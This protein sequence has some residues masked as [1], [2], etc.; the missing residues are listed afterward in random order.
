MRGAELRVR[1]GVVAACLIGLAGLV[2]PG[3]RPAG[4]SV[5]AVQAAPR[6]AALLTEGFEGGGLGG[7]TAGGLC[8]EEP[9]FCGWRVAADSVH[10]GSGAA[11]APGSGDRS[12]Q[13]LTSGPLVIPVNATLIDANFWHRYL[14]EAGHDGAVLEYSTDGGATWLD[15]GSRISPGY[16]GTIAS[17]Q[18]PL[19]GR[20][21]WTGAAPEWSQVTVDLRGLT[22]ATLY[23]R[24]RLGADE[25]LNSPGWWIDDVVVCADTA[26]GPARSAAAFAS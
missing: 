21:A 6:R 18:N 17:A 12:D 24:F 4:D 26:A 16:S 9:A 8:L 1:L 20:A 13:R 25:N 2:W 3:S 15:A 11:Y 23:L 5:A 19:N 7:F 22:G 10:S 14:T